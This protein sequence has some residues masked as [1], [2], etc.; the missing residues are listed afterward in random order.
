[1]GQK[2]YDII[3]DP[4]YADHIGSEFEPATCELIKSLASGQYALDVGANIGMTS[5]LLS[6]LYPRVLCFEPTPSTYSLLQINIELNKIN[7]VELFNFGLGEDDFTSDI[8]FAPGNRS[9]GFVSSTLT[10]SKGHEIEQVKI[11]RGDAL[12]TEP[13]FIK[14]DVE[15]YELHVIRG[16]KDTIRTF[17]PAVMFEVNHWCLNAFQRIALPDFLDEVRQIFPL[18]YAVDGRQRLNLHD[19]SDRYIFLHR[20]IVENRFLDVVGAFDDSR[21]INFHKLFSAD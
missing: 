12:R 9:G 21:L 8:T 13:S 16:L 7:N 18:L 11:I 10:A 20:N 5:L 15:G 4:V 17:R 3:S 19:E 14:I 6:E 1:M 2:K